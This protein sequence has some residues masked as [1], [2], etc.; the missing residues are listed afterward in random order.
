MSGKNKKKR[1]TL[2]LLFR[3][4]IGNVYW[5]SMADMDTDSIFKK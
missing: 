3:F 2:G 1:G 4:Y 5:W